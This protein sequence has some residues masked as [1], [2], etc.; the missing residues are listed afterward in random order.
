MNWR[1]VFNQQFRDFV[2]NRTLAAFHHNLGRADPARAESVGPERRSGAKPPLRDLGAMRGV[3]VV[4]MA[5]RCV[6]PVFLLSVALIAGC[7]GTTDPSSELARARDVALEFETLG[8]GDAPA[9]LT[10]RRVGDEVRVLGSLTSPC[11]PYDAGGSAF[12]RDDGVVLEVLGR[13]SGDCPQDAVSPLG[14]RAA[15]S[16]VASGA[17]LTITHRYADTNWPDT[18]VFH[19]V[20]EPTP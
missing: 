3:F 7:A 17:T 16:G 6:H 4:E 13:A 8:H 9:E 2:R 11:R 1:P 20:P 14:Y 12:R 10:V 18:T 19:G 5:Q 15:V